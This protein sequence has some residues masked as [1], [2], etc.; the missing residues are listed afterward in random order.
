MHPGSTVRCKILVAFYVKKSYR[1][2]LGTQYC[3]PKGSPAYIFI[4]LLPIFDL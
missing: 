1:V 2:P 3:E 4:R